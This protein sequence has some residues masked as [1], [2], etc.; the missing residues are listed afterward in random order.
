MRIISA[1]APQVG[2]TAEEKNAF[3]EDLEQYVHSI[4][5]E[6]VLLL[7]GDLN[8]H[9]GEGREGFDRWHGGY[10]YG[11]RNEE[12][13]RILEF[14]AMSD[15]LIANTQFRKRKSHL[16]TFTS[17][18]RETQIDFWMLRRRD[19]NILVDTNVIP[20]DHV[21]A[22][23]HLLVMD[24]K[25]RRPKKARA[26]TGT[27]RIKW[28][29]LKEQKDKVLPALLSCLTSSTGCTV[30]EQWNATANAI[31]DSALV[32]WKEHLQA[33]RRSKKRLGGGMMRCRPQLHERSLRTNAGCQ[34][35]G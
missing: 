19:R 20:S 26:R 8:G 30:E 21:A 35:V 11:T 14:A 10:G 32:S 5:D 24:L 1:Y 31:K 33:R 15:L 28:W 12:G 2:C 9:I 6:E 3:Y 4:E 17:G 23:H 16:V 27:Q 22:Q 29:K 34:L 25:I 13:Q 7:G 18:G